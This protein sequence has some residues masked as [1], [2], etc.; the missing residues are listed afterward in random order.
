MDYTFFAK[1][2]NSRNHR[3]AQRIKSGRILLR[4]CL[5]SYNINVTCI[6]QTRITRIIG[7][8]GAIQSK[9]NPYRN[10]AT[11]FL[12]FIET[13]TTIGY[14]RR[15]ITDKCGEAIF[16]LVVQYRVKNSPKIELQ[17][18]QKFSRRSLPLK[19]ASKFPSLSQCLMGTIIDAVLVG[20]IF[21]KLS[22]EIFQQYYKVSAEASAKIQL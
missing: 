8:N 2:K 4:I 12:F 1:L 20:C 16:L 18:S 13:E 19:P 9:I 21:I 15:S 11:A 7:W 22:K 14:G 6:S 17:I 3:I 10:F 5:F